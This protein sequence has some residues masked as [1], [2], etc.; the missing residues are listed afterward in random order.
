M[1]VWHGPEHHVGGRVSAQVRA[2]GLTPIRPMLGWSDKVVDQLRPSLHHPAGKVGG[3]W[4]A[5]TDRPVTPHMRPNGVR[6]D[7]VP[8]HRHAA[9][10]LFDLDPTWQ[11]PGGRTGQASPVRR[12]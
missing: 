5:T 4:P 9:R 6:H 1:G 8:T 10:D 7:I 3:R 11:V 2:P 12:R